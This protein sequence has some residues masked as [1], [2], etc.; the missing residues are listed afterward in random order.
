MSFQAGGRPQSFHLGRLV[1]RLVRVFFPRL[2]RDHTKGMVLLFA[3]LVPAASGDAQVSLDSAPTA[4]LARWAELFSLEDLL[5]G[6]TDVV[7]KAVRV[8]SGD[9]T[10]RLDFYSVGTA[11][12]SA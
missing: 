7:L 1:D 9:S 4:A 5:D 11:A 3:I 2:R 8:P 12:T 10:V 6:G